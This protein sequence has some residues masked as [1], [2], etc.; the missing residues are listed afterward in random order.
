MRCLVLSVEGREVGIAMLVRNRFSEFS[1]LYNF[2]ANY[3]SYI[4]GGKLKDRKKAMPR[5]LRSFLDTKSS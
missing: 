4:Q 5:V 1:S 2:F 3:E